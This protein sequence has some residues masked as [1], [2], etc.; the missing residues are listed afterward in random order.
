MP[1]ENLSARLKAAVGRRS[2]DTLSPHAKE[3][4]ARVARWKK[5]Q[6]EVKEPPEAVWC[7]VANRLGHGAGSTARLGGR[8]TGPCKAHMVVAVAVPEVNGKYETIATLSQLY[9]RSR[10]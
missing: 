1:E 9:E 2:P 8:G 6:T 4:W 7:L 3:V 5:S 10:P